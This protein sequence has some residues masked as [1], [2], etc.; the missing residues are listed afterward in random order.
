VGVAGGGPALYN[1]AKQESGKK[2]EKSIFRGK[3]R[4]A[5]EDYEHSCQRATLSLRERSR[6]EDCWKRRTTK[7]RR[8]QVADGA[9][10]LACTDS[11]GGEMPSEDE[12]RKSAEL[13][14]IFVTDLG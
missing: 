14:L 10:A 6:T 12:P 11:Y 1:N 3:P 5:E 9:W 13:V 8:R 7:A 4:F 2:R